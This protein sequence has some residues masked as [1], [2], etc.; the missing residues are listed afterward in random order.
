M[1]NAVPVGEGIMIAVLGLDI[2]KLILSKI[3]TLKMVF[4]RLLMIM[5]RD[6]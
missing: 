4:A 6:R 3:L 5:L 2:K 1:Q